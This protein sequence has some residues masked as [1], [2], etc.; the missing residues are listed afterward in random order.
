MKQLFQTKTT[1][2]GIKLNGIYY[3]HPD[4][5]QWVGQFVLVVTSKKPVNL[6]IFTMQGIFI[7]K[8]KADVFMET[9]A[10]KKACLSCPYYPQSDNVQKES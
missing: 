9:P 8:A 5:M 3:Y 4:L 6:N 1:R 10:S 2:N 7:C